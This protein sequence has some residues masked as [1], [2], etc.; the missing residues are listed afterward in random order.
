MNRRFIGEV[1]HAGDASSSGDGSASGGEIGILK[2][3]K[4]RQKAGFGGAHRKI[5][6]LNGKR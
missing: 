4:Q 2:T 6:G 3:E 5:G 1:N